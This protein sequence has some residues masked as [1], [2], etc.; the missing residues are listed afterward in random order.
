MRTFLARSRRLWPARGTMSSARFAVRASFT[1]VVVLCSTLCCTGKP[2]AQA[3]PPGFVGTI[4]DPNAVFSLPAVPRPAYRQTITDPTFQTRITRITGDPGT[5]ISPTLGVWGT[6]ARQV[7]SK[8]QPWNSTGTLLT[9]ENRSGDANSSPLIL[10]GET[11]QPKYTPCESFDNYEYRWHP[12]TSHPD[13]QIAVSR[14]GTELMWFD[15]TNCRKLRTWTL[16]FPADYGIGSG[17]GNVSADGRYAVISDDSRMVVVD[18]DPRGNAPAYPFKRIGPVYTFQPCSLKA[19]E[20]DFCP[21][22]NISISPSGRYIDVKFGSGGV[23]CDTLCDM[24]RI[25]EVDSSLT[26]RPHN[27]AATSLRCGEFANRPNGWVFPLKHA[28]MAADPFD[29]NEDVLIGGR[30]CPGSTLGRVV[31]V[32]LRD[33]KVTELTKPEN[34]AGYSHGSARATQRPGWFYVTYTRASSAIG[35]RFGGE[36]VAVKMDGSGTVQRFGHY[37]STAGTYRSQ[38]HGVPSPDGRRILFASDWAEGC[39]SG[40]GSTSVFSGYVI[41]ARG[42]GDTTAPAPVDDLHKK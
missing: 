10:D 6:D 34:E 22:G 26:I 8:Q 41:D 13:V 42:G 7:Y 32:R 24:H 12:S 20:P 37:H 9:I 30:A 5:V 36:I 31:K 18:M 11:Y 15:V 1:V 39:G 28:D 23:S 38:A 4:M 27:M 2:R 33:G 29:N 14:S 3:V 21:N 19:G 16:P 25:F 35:R 40:C 17:E